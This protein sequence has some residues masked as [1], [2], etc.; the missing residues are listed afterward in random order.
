MKLDIPDF[1]NIKHYTNKRKFRNRHPLLPQWAFNMI[2]SGPTGS[3]KS[4]LTYALICKFLVFD[5]LYL[6]TRH[7]DQP[8]VQM[9]ITFFEKIEKKTGE[10]ILHLENDIENLIP[11]DDLDPDL[12]NL[13]IFDDFIMSNHLSNITEYYVR[14]RHKNCSTIFLTQIYTKVPRPIRLNSQYFAFFKVPNRKELQ[15]LYAEVGGMLNK[16]VFYDLFHK[17][18]KDPYQFF[19]IDTRA[20]TKELMFRK[21]FDE[22]L[23]DD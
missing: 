15:L 22:I 12:Q 16:E 21:N 19:F 6:Y 10:D 7:T 17:A 18:T 8:G 5:K 2:I 11:L 1:S 3:G 23:V 14:G 9:L 4:W 20:K 13:V